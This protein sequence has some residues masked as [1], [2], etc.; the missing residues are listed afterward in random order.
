MST[1]N[2]NQSVCLFLIF[3]SLLCYSHTLH[4]KDCNYVVVYVEITM[5]FQCI[6]VHNDLLVNKAEQL[7]V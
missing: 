7:P 6:L 5:Q 1:L 4:Y 3:N 2:T